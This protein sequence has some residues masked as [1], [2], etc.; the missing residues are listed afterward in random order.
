[1][2]MFSKLRKHLRIS[3]RTVIIGEAAVLLGLCLCLFLFQ[4]QAGQAV[5][6]PVSYTHLDVYKRQDLIW[7]CA[8]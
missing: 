5:I 3:L 1:M 8:L 4:T 2:N 6:A 7:G